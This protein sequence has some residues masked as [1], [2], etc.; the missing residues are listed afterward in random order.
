MISLLLDLSGPQVVCRC[1]TIKQIKA[2]TFEVEQGERSSTSNSEGLPVI[3]PHGLRSLNSLSSTT[4][5][6][7][8]LSHLG[9]SRNFE[10]RGTPT[11]EQWLG[12]RLLCQCGASRLLGRLGVAAAQPYFIQYHQKLAVEFRSYVTAWPC[13]WM[14]CT[15]LRVDDHA[16][17]V[18]RTTR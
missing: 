11:H 18:P 7:G 4:A 15:L 12:M 8:I 16:V 14:Y 17:T 9:N 13:R 10:R 6:L 5:E 2:S 1:D 3:T